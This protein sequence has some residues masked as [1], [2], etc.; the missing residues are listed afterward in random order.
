MNF[1]LEIVFNVFI[2]I[3]LYKMLISTLSVAVLKVFVNNSDTLQ[4]EKKS[5]R[6]KLKD[7]LADNET[8]AN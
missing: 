4:K 2:G 7:K 3:M 6:D 8:K 1:N 5:F